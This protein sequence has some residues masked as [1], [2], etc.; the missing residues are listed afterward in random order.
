MDNEPIFGSEA[1]N[2]LNKIFYVDDMLNSVPSVPDLVSLLKK[3]RYICAAGG[4][5]LTK[6]VINSK[7]VLLSIPENVRSEL[8]KK[9]LDNSVS[10][11][12]FLTYTKA[13]LSY[14][15]RKSK[16]F[17]T[18]VA[19]QIQII[20]E[21]QDVDHRH[22]IPTESNPGNNSFRGIHPTKLAKVEM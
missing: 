15:K 11:E 18:F 22:C 10:K 3:A 6:F 7:E 1:A 4:F 2:T 9:E 16:R 14:I 17:K 8:L 19:N 21:L 5:K 13:I 20:K 12:I